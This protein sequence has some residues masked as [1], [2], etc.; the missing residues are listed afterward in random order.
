M[1]DQIETEFR[2][3]FFRQSDPAERNRILKEMLRRE[4]ESIRERFVAGASGKAAA[5][6]YSDLVDA[7][8]R[9][10]FEVRRNTNAAA[11]E[12][13]LVAVG[14]YGRREMCP[15]SDVDL[16]V[17]IP[18]KASPE[19]L[20]EAEHI[21][22]PL[23]DMGFVVGQSV[24]T[25]A[26]CRKATED[27]V[28]T[29]TAF[30]QERFLGGSFPLYREFADFVAERPSGRR[31]RRLA[32]LKLAEREK[33]LVAQGHLAQ[34]LEPN[35]KEG[36]G[37]LRDLHTLLWLAGIQN[38]ARN[39]DDLVRAGIVGPEEL[40]SVR[41]AN[42]FLLRARIALH[43]VTEHKSDRLGFGEQ[44]S[45][46]A[47][48]GYRDD[49]DTKAV[50]RFQK[51]FYR[52]VR[53][54][55]SLTSQYCDHVAAIGSRR[56]RVASP[57]PRFRIDDGALEI[58]VD[59]AN[60]FLS[61][62]AL[63]LDVFRAAQK[64]QVGAGPTTRWYVRQA[65][66]LVQPEEIDLT[67]LLPKLLEIMRHSS[68]RGFTL[69]ELHRLGVINLVVPDF[70]LIDCHSQHDIYHLYTTDE[71]TLTV[72]CRLATLSKSDDPVLSHLKGELAR[73]PDLDVLYIAALF[74]DVGKGLGADHSDSGARLVRE[75]CRKAGFS[76]SR[77][78]QAAQ[79]VQHH[80][81]LNYL[82]QRRDIDDPR[83][84]RDLLARIDDAH[85]LRKLYVL[86]WADTSS[87]HPDAWSAWKASLLQRLYSGAMLEIEQEGA[88]SR[89][90]SEE[91]REALAQE[92]AGHSRDEVLEHIRR[93]PRR[94]ASSV[95]A[96]QVADHLDLVQSL[97]SR[98]RCAAKVRNEGSHKE[99]SLVLVDRPGLLAHICAAL[100]EL[101]L[102][103]VSSQVYTRTDGVAIDIFSVIPEDAAAFAGDE[104]M[105]RQI[106]ERV[107]SLLDMPVESLQAHVD[108]QVRRWAV[109]EARIMTPK[110]R[111]EFHD[112]DSD[113]YT[114]LDVTAPDRLGL[115]FD[116]TLYLSK[117]QWVIHSAR[118]CTE[119]D[120]ALD[121][122]SI[123]TPEGR[124]VTDGEARRSARSD[125]LRLL[126]S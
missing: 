114:I 34:T 111:V 93:M 27:D 11:S 65:V 71:H 96:R 94:Y 99:A 64:A 56:S 68:E 73:I 6:A 17:L 7:F 22:Y 57:D 29:Y 25:V 30:L 32:L 2:Q 101:R 49:G 46:A 37:C 18:R 24:R 60:P 28:E 115:L 112:Q 44:E 70:R 31:Q 52:R 8:L 105:S 23:W 39:M 43:Y 83:T 98:R 107:T 12:L 100:T 103:I 85:L 15:R 120:K 4:R 97:S 90:D 126:Q 82:A 121:S 84:I 75:Y 9:S 41:D 89:I 88:T 20:A 21:L 78:L 47:M 91:R 123:T 124:P 55:D 1:M 77:A 14:G 125:L 86:T 113:D 61:N 79:L 95:P 33:R 81:L 48:L 13:A 5:A 74:H 106:E 118:V 62:I 117:R 66:S 108:A 50:E 92:V 51:D 67:T 16:L 35:L 58:E 102:S 72:L 110:A 10:V 122:F 26:D 54:V 109:G 53:T 104:D 119:A 87:V 40:G 76:E 69:R 42:E 116:L 45:V 36:R 3:V 63:V 80:L 19:V 59:G 38:G